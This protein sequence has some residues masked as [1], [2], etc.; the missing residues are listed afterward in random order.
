MISKSLQV[1][2]LVDYLGMTDKLNTGNMN[3][4]HNKIANKLL[5]IVLLY[6]PINVYAVTLNVVGGELLGATNVSV[7]GSLYDVSFVDGTCVDI[8]NGCDSSSDFT[9]NLQS[10]AL[11]A[12]QALLDQVFIDGVDGDFNSDATLTAGIEYAFD[13]AGTE[14]WAYIYTNYEVGGSILRG[15]Y[16]YF[17]NFLIYD[18]TNIYQT[19]PTNDNSTIANQTWAVWSNASSPSAVPVPAA[20][21]LFGSGLIGL[22]GVARRKNA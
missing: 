17:D 8:F 9:F 11:A 15:A 20:V 22:I 10:Q 13:P 2:S 1:V 6:V 14:A 21:W 16:A 7:G 3:M 5:L 12:S 4:K 19:T 18:S